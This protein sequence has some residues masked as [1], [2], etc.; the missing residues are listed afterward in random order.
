M[1]SESLFLTLEIVM[2]SSTPKLIFPGFTYEEKERIILTVDKESINADI[3]N[4][5]L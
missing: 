2:K 1:L 5:I 4:T 3:I